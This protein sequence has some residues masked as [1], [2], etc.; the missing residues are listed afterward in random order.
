MRLRNS[1]LYQLK[2][3]LKPI[4]IFYSIFILLTV[5][6]SISAFFA[7]DSI[8]QMSGWDFGILIF[9]FIMGCAC[10]NE[11][12]S[13][14]LQNSVSRKTYFTAKLLSVFSSSAIM[15]AFYA[16]FTLL[17]HWIFQYLLSN[18]TVFEITSVF[19]MLYFGGEGIFSFS[20]YLWTALLIF[21]SAVFVN[22]LGMFISGVFYRTGKLTR[23]LLAAGIPL[24]FIM[25]FPMVDYTFFGGTLYAEVF[26]FIGNVF[27]IFEKTPW[28]ATVSFGVLFAV[29]TVAAWLVIRKAPI[30]NK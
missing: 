12:F 13:M 19:E 27:G 2:G 16:A 30:K 10:F 23:I 20:M 17:I 7:K 21:T 14:H 4:T 18:F 1:Y 26:K 15:T 8:F 25:I 24:F 11:D 29:S 28:K 3:S 22:M 5:V 6:S 9:M